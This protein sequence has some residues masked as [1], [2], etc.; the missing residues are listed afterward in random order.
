ML[1]PPKLPPAFANFPQTSVQSVPVCSKPSRDREG[2]VFSS[3]KWLRSANFP[4]LANR[5]HMMTVSSSRRAQFGFELHRACQ[6][7]NRGNSR[8]A[9]SRSIVR[10][11]FAEIP[12]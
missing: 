1:T 9:F 12:R 10:M 4:N 3:P 2:A 6:A 5:L 7:L 11:T 8:S